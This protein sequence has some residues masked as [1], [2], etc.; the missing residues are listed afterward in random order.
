[1]K[2]REAQPEKGISAEPDR[3]Q[4]ISVDDVPKTKKLRVDRT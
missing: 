2:R 4:E 1:M 3:E